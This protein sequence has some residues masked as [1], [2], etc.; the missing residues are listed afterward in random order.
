MEEFS[1]ET[2]KFRVNIEG[3]VKIGKNYINRVI[4]TTSTCDLSD[5]WLIQISRE[6]ES[7]QQFRILKELILM[8]PS[9]TKNFELRKDHPLKSIE[10]IIPEMS[11]ETIQEPNKEIIVRDGVKIFIPS[12]FR[13]QLLGELHKYALKY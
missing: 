8:K 7:C 13:G 2:P 11:L 5:P 4:R 9:L 6:G 10:N 3:Q 1:L 12:Q